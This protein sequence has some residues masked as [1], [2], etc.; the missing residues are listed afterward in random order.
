MQCKKSRNG[1]VNVQEPLFPFQCSGKEQ[2]VVTMILK[3][4]LLKH[5]LG[6]TPQDVTVLS[7]KQFE[8]RVGR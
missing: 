8:S 5:I 7:L 1:V 4:L 2:R 6:V 3:I